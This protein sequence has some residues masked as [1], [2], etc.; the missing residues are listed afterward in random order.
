MAPEKMG[1]VQYYASVMEME[2][3]IAYVSRFMNTIKSNHYPVEIG[4]LA[5]LWGYEGITKYIHGLPEVI[6][7]TDHNSMATII[8]NKRLHDAKSRPSFKG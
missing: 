4:I 3:S 2:T 7:E 1:S 6:I 5:V 8:N